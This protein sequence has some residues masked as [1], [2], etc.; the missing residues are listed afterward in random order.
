MKIITPRMDNLRHVIEMVFLRRDINEVLASLGRN[1]FSIGSIVSYDSLKTLLQKY[2]AQYSGNQYNALIDVAFDKWMT[3][4]GE[5][6]L[7]NLLQACTKE[8]L[9]KKGYSPICYYDSYLRW[10]EMSSLVGEDILTCSYLAKLSTETGEEQRAFTWKPVL[11]SDNRRI[12]FIMQK[13]L[14]ELHYHLQGSSLTFDVSWMALMNRLANESEFKEI[15]NDEKNWY[16]LINT[17]AMLR[18]YLFL[19]VNK[20]DTYRDF[21][22]LIN[23]WMEE[24]DK[25]SFASNTSKEIMASIHTI[26]HNYGLRYGK[27]VLD[28][29]IPSYLDEVDE[30]NYFNVPLVGE[31]KLL[32]FCFKMIY[33]QNEPCECFEA[34]LYTY[35]LIK[36]QFRNIMILSISPRG[37]E[38]FQQYEKNKD[39]FIPKNTIYRNLQLFLSSQT[40]LCNQPINYIEYRITPSATASSLRKKIDE[41]QL[42]FEDNNF[43]MHNPNQIKDIEYGFILHFIKQADSISDFNDEL[44]NEFKC[45]N[46]KVREL[47]AK[48]TRAI[49]SLIQQSKGNKIVGIDAANSEFGC[50]PE[51]YADAYRE[52][53]QYQIGQTFHVGEDFYDLIDGLRSIDEAVLFLNLKDGARL[54]HAIALGL[55]ATLYYTNNHY[56]TFMPKHDLLDNLAWV[57]MKM[58]EFGIEDIEGIHYWL[59]CKYMEYCN[60]VYEELI[61]VHTYYQSWMLRGDNPK[62]YLDKDNNQGN[63]VR[64][65]N[66]VNVMAEIMI[67]RRNQEACRVYSRYHY[68]SHVKSRGFQPDEFKIPRKFRHAFVTVLT[69]IQDKM[70]GTIALKH[71][72]IETNLTSNMRICDMARYSQHPIIRF[73]D[74]GL[75]CI[76]EGQP[77][78]TPQILATI[79]TDDQG[80]FATSLEKEFTLMLLALEKQADAHGNAI[81]DQDSIYQ[82]LDKVRENAFVQ[83]FKR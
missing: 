17:A 25:I 52:L 70:I 24:E 75:K 32:Y 83:K 74:V 14:A 80:I 51:V 2:Y 54:G 36:H 19:C 16:S 53:D 3:I 33:G 43:L 64:I 30:K 72:G 5:R 49:K 71:I 9:H 38:N 27:E 13:G 67:A 50:R 77:R 29:A 76:H 62:Q 57:Q 20:D 56:T 68:D 79:N 1:D 63:N 58:D 65:L 59:S 73:Y 60:E 22:Q 12:D 40:T 39:I 15:K 55:D 7:Y 23:R 66:T 37:F 10:H 61:D 6:N 82:W 28:Y 46:T 41:Y 81:Y 42:A 78:R 45:R 35:L 47:L 8:L 69:Q 44:A 4:D 26:C 11:G 31:R 18:A 34:L 48:Q 21:S